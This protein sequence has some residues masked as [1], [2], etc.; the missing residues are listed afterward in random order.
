MDGQSSAQFPAGGGGISNLQAKG[1]AFFVPENLS[2]LQQNVFSNSL[3]AEATAFWNAR[4]MMHH[5]GRE[6]SVLI[7]GRSVL[8]PMEVKIF[9]LGYHG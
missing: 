5:L 7:S 4:I 6:W 2:E 9:C 8:W 1:F 3:V